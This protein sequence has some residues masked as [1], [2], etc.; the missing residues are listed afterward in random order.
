MVN[1]AAADPGATDESDRASIRHVVELSRVPCLAQF[2]EWVQEWA[3]PAAEQP[4]LVF[5]SLSH[6]PGLLV[7]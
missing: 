3:Q 5:L 1:R 7:P 6:A 2:A 4:E